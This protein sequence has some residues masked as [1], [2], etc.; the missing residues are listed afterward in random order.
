MRCSL[1]LQAP[2][3]WQQP[4]RLPQLQLR[5]RPVQL[6]ALLAAC[7][8]LGAQHLG[9]G[10]AQKNEKGELPSLRCYCLCLLQHR[11]PQ[12][13]GCL[14]QGFLVPQEHQE[15]KHCRLLHQHQS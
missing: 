4:Q 2:R 3:R 10:H 12:C 5:R 1:A 6:P 9:L 7:P 11:W 15:G 14:Q 13:P 8:Q